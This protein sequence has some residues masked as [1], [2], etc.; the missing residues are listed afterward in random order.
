MKSNR[1][2]WYFP[3]DWLFFFLWQ[4]LPIVCLLLMPLIL[5][6][7][8]G[9]RQGDPTFLWIAAILAAVGIVLLFLARLPLYRQGR[10]FAFG[11]KA[12]PAG[13][14]KVYRIAY[15]FIGVSVAMM[16]ALLAVLR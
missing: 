3:R 16:L 9:T 5:W 2:E 12:L 8:R 15:D 14:R 6:F 10:Y 1:S 7:V 4:T 11:S 13:H